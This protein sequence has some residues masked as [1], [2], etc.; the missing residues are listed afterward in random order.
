MISIVKDTIIIGLGKTLSSLTSIAASFY[1]AKKFST[2]EMETF[3]ITMSAIAISSTLLQFGLQQATIPLLSSAKNKI[4]DRI[5]ITSESLLKFLI[6]SIIL[7]AITTFPVIQILLTWADSGQSVNIINVLAIGTTVSILTV[8]SEILRY[9]KKIWR[10]AIFSNFSYFI[11]LFI[12]AYIC[13]KYNTSTIDD[14]Y[15]LSY[16]ISTIF[17]ILGII[18]AWPSEKTSLPSEHRGLP[19]KYYIRH[20]FPIWA[21]SVVITIISQADIIILSSLNGNPDEVSSYG[22][23]LRFSAALSLVHIVAVS[24]LTRHIS[25]YYFSNQHDQLQKILSLS[26]NILFSIGLLTLIIHY[27][28]SASAINSHLGEGYNSAYQASVFLMIGQLFKLSSGMSVTV[29]ILTNRTN[30]L[31]SI[32]IIS[33][34]AIITLS[35]ATAKQFGAAGVAIS[36]M[37]GMILMYTASMIWIKKT[38]NLNCFMSIK[39][40]LKKR[41]REKE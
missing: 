1:L 26:S 41:E 12:S 25:T 38:E 15:S 19:L 36:D 31:F 8:A 14:I 32:S 9:R 20:L 2:S 11:S 29:L 18:F 23:A 34:F 30:F 17:T 5:A 10:S 37:I 4:N 28:F 27:I 13:T 6:I 39:P 16:K 22:I 21:S 35:I 40:L 33:G 7:F 3:F 24:S